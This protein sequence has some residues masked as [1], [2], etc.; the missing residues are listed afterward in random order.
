M[1]TTTKKDLGQKLAEEVQN[2]APIYSIVPECVMQNKEL[3]KNLSAFRTFTIFNSYAGSSGACWA[4]N[5]K[6]QEKYPDQ[7]EDVIRKNL[8]ILVD[9]DLV[10][11]TLDRSSK[12]GTKRILVFPGNWRNYFEM[13]K[14]VGRL[15]EAAAV[16]AFFEGRPF[17]ECFEQIQKIFNTRPPWPVL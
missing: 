8:K 1:E 5:K 3:S 12:R 15:K 10:F 13:C 4:S 11:R 7:T 14:E 17:D 16:Q 2:S 6:I 9:Q